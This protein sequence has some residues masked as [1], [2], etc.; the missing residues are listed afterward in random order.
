VTF[1]LNRAQSD[2]NGNGLQDYRLLAR[3]WRS[4]YTSPDN[5][6]NIATQAMLSGHK[7]LSDRLTLSANA[8]WRS[9]VTR[10]V[11]G[12]MN[13]DALGES[14]YQPNATERAALAAA[15]YTG[16]PTSGE[17]QANTTFPKWRCIAN[18]LLNDEPNEKC[19]GLFT[20]SSTRQQEW[21]GAVELAWA[22]QLAGVEQRLTIGA[23]YAQARARFI[24]NSQFGYLLPDHS[25]AVVD[26][27]GAYADGSQSSENAFDAR[28]DLHSRISSL[29]LYAADVLALSDR[30]RVTL[31]GR[32]DRTRLRN[33]DQ[34]TPGGGTGSL[35][36]DPVF[37][38]FNPSAM[39][40]WAVGSGLTL[41]AQAGRVRARHRRSNWDVRTRRRH[42]A[43]PMRWRAIRRCGKWWPAASRWAQRWSARHGTCA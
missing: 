30:V 15:G 6:R 20:R 10:S 34:I 3:D 18:V 43:C 14:F 29:G 1:T 11:N 27:P 26:G 32:Y 4:V 22:G 33:R 8:F 23:S 28:V 41:T 7:K 13:E 19:N 38:R 40:D 16:Y 31:A 25:V 12:D 2:L 24:Q 37:Q 5:T 35:D 9:I 39:V 42:A 36:A 21:G 17:T